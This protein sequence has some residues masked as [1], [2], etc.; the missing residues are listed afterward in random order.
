MITRKEPVEFEW[1]RGNQDKNWQRHKVTTKEAE[2]VFFDRNR[3]IAKDFLH[4]KK[5]DRYLLIGST[6]QKRKLFIVFTQRDRK[7]R[8]ISARDLNKKEYK[9]L[10]K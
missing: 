4:S 2:E 6:T 5:E 3:R 9:L 1:D 7:I 10:K 8:I